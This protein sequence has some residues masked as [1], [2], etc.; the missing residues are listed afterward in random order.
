MSNPRKRILKVDPFKLIARGA[1]AALKVTGYLLASL[2][3]TFW[4]IAHGKRELIGDA[5]ARFGRDETNAIADIFR[6]H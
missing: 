1:L 3:Q 5:I 4:Y 2:A 6:D